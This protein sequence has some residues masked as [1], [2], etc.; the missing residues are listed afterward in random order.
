M[1]C[2]MIHTITDINQMEAAGK[3]GKEGKKR[4]QD[5]LTQESKAIY[6]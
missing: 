1:F 3:I 4:T 6:M 2:F 5:A